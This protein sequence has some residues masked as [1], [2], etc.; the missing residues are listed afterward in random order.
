MNKLFLSVIA[1]TVLSFQNNAFAQLEGKEGMLERQAQAITK[2]FEEDRDAEVSVSRNNGNYVISVDGKS[3]CSLKESL[4]TTA[5][6]LYSCN[7][8]YNVQAFVYTGWFGGI[9]AKFV[10]FEKGSTEALAFAETKIGQRVNEESTYTDG[11]YDGG[12]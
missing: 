11:P 7:A 8:A 4:V 10:L 2:S 5:K 1:L 12:K 6:K 3:A 9:W